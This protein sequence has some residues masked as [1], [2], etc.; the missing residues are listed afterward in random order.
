MVHLLRNR[1]IYRQLAASSAWPPAALWVLWAVLDA[2]EIEQL[3]SAGVAVTR[4]A[5]G[6]DAADGAGL[7][8]A[9]EII[10]EHHPGQSI[11]VDGV[12]QD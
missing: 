9:I 7:A 2:A 11:W 5:Q 3:R 12:R 4:F 6:F 8:A 10:G 1:A